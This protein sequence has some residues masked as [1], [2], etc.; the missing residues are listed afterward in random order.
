MTEHQKML[1]KAKKVAALL[2][3][4]VEGEV[5]AA[6]SMLKKLL[7]EHNLS[8]AE[9]GLRG[10][11]LNRSN[12]VVNDRIVETEYKHVYDGMSTW[13]KNMVVKIAR[14]YGVRTGV[15][16]E[17]I[18]LIGYSADVEIV[19]IVIV[20]LRRYIQSQIFKRD[21]TSEHSVTSY[22]CGLMDKIIQSI[23]STYTNFDKVSKLSEY[24]L[25]SYGV[26]HEPVQKRFQTEC[27]AYQSGRSDA[28]SYQKVAVSYQK[29]A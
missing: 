29:V 3:S 2:S 13:V 22:T 8:L 19:K 28:V 6:A 17:Y 11:N 21:Y 1:N 10:I 18:R 15:Q 26:T 23:G 20:N 7:D 12:V 16:S 14:A 25:K 5:I 4:P 24:M 9:I 27:R